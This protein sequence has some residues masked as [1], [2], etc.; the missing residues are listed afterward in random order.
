MSLQIPTT[1]ELADTIIAQLQA[2]LNQLIPLL[3]IAFNRVMSV[4]VAGVF[5]LLYKYGGWIFLQM[6]VSQAQ[7]K[8]SVING[9][10][11]N[12]LVMWGE[13]IGIGTPL[14]A[15]RAEYIVDI[16]VN[17]QVGS[18]DNHT[19]L[20]DTDSGVT[21]LTIGPTLLDAPTVQATV[22]AS[23]D[24][25]GNGGVGTIGNLVIGATLSF[26]KPPANTQSEATV[27][28]EVVVGVDAESTEAYRLRIVTRFQQQPQGGAPVDYQLWGL[29]DPDMIY[30]YPYKGDPGIVEVY[31]EAT[32]ASSGSADGIPTSAQLVTVKEDYIDIDVDG[33]AS[34]RPINDWVSTLPIERLGYDVFI[35]GLQLDGTAAELQQLKDNIELA[36]TN[37]FVALA[38]FIYGVTIPP[39]KDQVS[40]AAVSGTIQDVVSASG[41]LFE[42]VI[43]E[44]NG[45]SIQLDILGKGQKAKMNSISF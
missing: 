14:P 6:F 28:T 8:E 43:L 7:N 42:G 40:R 13:L 17:N 19:Q 39:K 27:V 15:T 35:S 37:Y 23:G 5:I 18:L 36:L 25:D 1:K 9:K 32:E 11:I 45:A 3:P 30:A 31:F 24:Q 33:L 41:G 12:P 10:T 38:P 2:T 26:V 34:N 22:R 16:V 4:A 44:K 29:N 21:Y 20:L